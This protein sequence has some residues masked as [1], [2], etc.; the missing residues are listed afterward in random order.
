M[1]E[2]GVSHCQT[3]QQCHF[4]VQSILHVQVSFAAVIHIYV[5]HEAL[6]G[7]KKIH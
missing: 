4:D 7:C 3:Q 1:F 6:N 5:F 2:S